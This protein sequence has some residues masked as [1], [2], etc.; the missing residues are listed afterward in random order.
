MPDPSVA[1]LL[2]RDGTPTAAQLHYIAASTHGDRL[3]ALRELVDYCCNELE[4]YR[5]L[6]KNLSE[7]QLTIEIVSNLSLLGIEADHDPQHG[8]HCDI[9]VKGRD[10]FIW[11][12]E[13]K[14]HS[15]Y[16]W[17]D[18]GFKQLTTRY[19]TGVPGQDNGE[20]LIYCKASNAKVKLDKWHRELLK[21]NDGISVRSDPNGDPLAFWSVHKHKGSG[22]DFTTRHKIVCLHH[23]PAE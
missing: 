9:V 12:A 6:K 13:A 8:G 19:S 11:I 10:R 4:K 17:L 18:K 22:M 2:A 5:H 7:D 23:E 1:E 3:S 15:S 14:T 20:I 16:V 21:R